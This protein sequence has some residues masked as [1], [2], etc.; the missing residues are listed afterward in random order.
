MNYSEAIEI[1]Y[2]Q[3]PMFQHVG[4]SAYKTGLGTTYRLDEYFG[5]RHRCYKT[6][7]VAGTNGKGSCSH[8]VAAVLAESGYKVGLY[9]SPHLRDFRERIRVNGVMI[10]EADV[11]AFVE[12]SLPL[13]AELHPSFFELTTAMAFDYFAKAEVDVAVVEVGLGGRLD[14]TNIIMPELSVITNISLDHT[15]L[16]GG[17]LQSIARE[18]AGIIKR[19]VPVVI[20][21]TQP[22]VEDVFRRKA[23]EM[24]APVWFADKEK[25]GAVLPDCEM[26]GIYQ[27]INRRTVLTVI[28]RLRALGFAIPEQAVMSGFAHVC[29]LTGIMGRWQTLSS[30]PRVVCDTGHNEAGMRFVVGQLAGERYSTLRIVIGMVG[31]KDIAHILD[32]LPRNAVYYFTNARIPRALDA[33]RLRERGMSLGL[34]GEA[35]PTVAAALEAAKSDAVKASES[36]ADDL[37]FV[38]G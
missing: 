27:N 17:T 6:I 12:R 14:C 38:G 9:T 30:C 1:L 33:G 15:D 22:E 35:Y 31:D 13:V 8:L 24:G 21:E 19:G 7:H 36:G 28:D 26:K 3:A 16:L 10:P 23:A 25:A 29:R 2:N 34:H 20:G 4:K 11:C 37:I 32:Q 18:K 5:H